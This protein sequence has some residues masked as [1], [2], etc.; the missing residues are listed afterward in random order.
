VLDPQEEI[1]RAYFFGI[2][3]LFKM[4]LAFSTKTVDNF[5]SKSEEDRQSP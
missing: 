3:Q 2:Q 4:A 5:V 1:S